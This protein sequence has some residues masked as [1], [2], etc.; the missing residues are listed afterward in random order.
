M[1]QNKRNALLNKEMAEKMITSEDY[2]G[3]RDK[4]VEA[5]KLFPMLENVSSMLT[6][7]DILCAASIKFPGCGVDNYWVLQLRP[8]ANDSDIKSRYWKLVGMLR[9]VKN[10]FPGAELAFKL[11]QDAFTVLL[12]G[13]QRFGFDLKRCQS[14]R[15][16][17]AHEITN[18][19]RVETA[20]SSYGTKV[21][22]T[23]E[24]SDGSNKENDV[25]DIFP[26]IENSQQ[27]K[28]DSPGASWISSH[29][30][31]VE[32]E[33]IDRVAESTSSHTTSELQTVIHKKRED[34]FFNFNNIRRDEVFDVGQIWA[35]GYQAYLPRRYAMITNKSNF[36]LS[37]AW[38]KPVPLTAD[39]RRWCQA[40]IPVSC[41][42]FYLDT[43]M[44]QDKLSGSRIFSHICSPVHGLTEEF[45]IY[46]KIGEVWAIYKDWDLFEWS[47]NLELLKGGKFEIVEI[48]EDYLKYTGALVTRLIKVDGFKNIYQRDN[49]EESNSTFHIS[50]T[51]LYIFSHYIPSFKFMGGEMDK[52]EEGMFELDLLA[53]PQD[54]V[55]FKPLNE[56]SSSNISIVTEILPPLKPQAE[57]QSFKGNWSTNDISVGQIWALY[58]GSDAMPRLYALINSFV[59]MSH[60]IVTYLEPQPVIDVEI[61]WEKENLPIVCGIFRVGK[62]VQTLEMLW[63]S[64]PAKFQRSTNGVFYKIYPRKGEVW[65]MYKNWNK[66]WSQSDYQNYQ[67]RIVEILSDFSDDSGVKIVRL[68]EVKGCMTFFQRHRYDGFELT[69]AVSK[70]EML[71]FSHRIPAFVVPGI[72]RYGIPENAWH[73]E[74][75]ALPPRH[76]T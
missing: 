65:A 67:C 62:T 45:E 37:V 43:D 12:D 14:W 59:S 39:E 48:L 27:E 72:G 2:M 46:P 41:G 51:N 44:M 1:D 47:C 24:I 9:P 10:T 28:I 49:E 6:V 5:K 33:E 26:K 31:P 13:G 55:N 58:S 66:K 73:L 71:S 52:I 54:G 19:D 15:N 74:P 35:T 25:T 68:V 42:S 20:Q 57:T 64:C 16:C 70:A 69:R 18:K 56:T 50:P 7:C 4:L 3:A 75:D 22:S 38:F 30:V 34:N 60:V 21:A 29:V 61:S 76:I 32:N 11:V 40:D 23:S 36:E 63:F 17:G 8:S 53:L